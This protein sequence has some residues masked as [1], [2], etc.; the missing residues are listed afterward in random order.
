MHARDGYLIVITL[1]GRSR[2]MEAARKETVNLRRNGLVEGSTYGETHE[3][4]TQETEGS[5]TREVG[6]AFDK[7]D[8]TPR[9]MR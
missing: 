6:M 2:R 5:N 7:H 3:L 1:I 8:F 4:R 9:A